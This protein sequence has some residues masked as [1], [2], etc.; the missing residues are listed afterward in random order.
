MEALA[1]R[2]GAASEAFREING[3]LTGVCA[4]QPEIRFSCGGRYGWAVSHWIGKK[5][6]CNVFAEA[7]AVTV[8]MRL[9]DRQ[10]AALHPRLLPYT[11]RC[12]NEKY[13]CGD[14]GWIHDRV[15]SEGHVRDIRTL[16][17][18]K[19][20]LSP[21]ERRALPQNVNFRLFLRRAY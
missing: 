17:G 8:M 19:C 9:S 2:G 18:L 13:P 7:D 4:M 15:L 5:R 20:G 21:H 16:L 12:I 11:Q 10:Y 6:I 14:G 3:Y 1:A